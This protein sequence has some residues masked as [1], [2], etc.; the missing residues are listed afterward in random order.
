MTLY[1]FS[2]IK[3]SKHRDHLSQ[4][5]GNKPFISVSIPLSLKNSISNTSKFKF[6]DTKSSNTFNIYSQVHPNSIQNTSRSDVSANKN[7]NIKS[8][9]IKR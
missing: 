1:D 7:V 4:H 5:Y 6:Y 9:C 8:W 3:I 2:D